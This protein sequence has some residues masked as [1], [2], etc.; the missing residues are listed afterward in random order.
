QT[1]GKIF[2]A[3]PE[4]HKDWSLKGLSGTEIYNTHADFKDEAELISVFRP[5]NQAG[6]AKLLAL[7]NA[8]KAYPQECFAA[9][10]DPPLDNLATFEARA[11]DGPRAAIAGNDYHQNTGFVLRG[12]ADGQI[13]VEDP[14]GEKIGML[15]ANKTPTLK[16]LFGEPVPGKELFRRVLDPYP[17]S[18]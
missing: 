2:V 14:L 3:H 7:L 10:F 13:A 17:V 5:R 12:E 4:E 16:T 11:K 6:Y 18:F 9:L 15:D 1:G 8:F